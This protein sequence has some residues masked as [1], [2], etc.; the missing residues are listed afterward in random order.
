MKKPVAASNF[1][2][3]FCLFMVTFP[4]EVKPCFLRS[5]VMVMVS[6]GPLLLFFLPE[7]SLAVDQVDL[8]EVQ[9][10]LVIPHGHDQV[11][12]L[13]GA[14][15]QAA[16]GNLLDAVAL[17]AGHGVYFPAKIEVDAM[18]CQKSESRPFTVNMP[19]EL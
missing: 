11:V 19:D 6:H 3:S 12:G 14:A 17:G 8:L 16:V 13:G 4:I 9:H 1:L 2:A 10:K 15:D 7:P 18:I 5:A